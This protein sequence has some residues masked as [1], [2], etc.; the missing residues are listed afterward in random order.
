MSQHP[1]HREE[2]CDTADR[3]DRPEDSIPQPD[4]EQPDDFVER[5]VTGLLEA[6]Y[7]LVVSV[8]VPVWALVRF[9]CYDSW[10]KRP[11]DW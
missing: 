1:A 8:A 10:A 11:E 9:I 2:R 3:R 7:G 5:C 6:V 4:G